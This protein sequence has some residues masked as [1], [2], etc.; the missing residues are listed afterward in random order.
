MIQRIQTVF[1]MI[2]AVALGTQVATPLVKSSVTDTAYYRDSLLYLK[3]YMPTLVLLIVT[4]ALV[5]ITIFLFKNR[6]LQKTLV[7]AGIV[8]ILAT[9]LVV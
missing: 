1:L 5:L 6:K 8:G 2:A 9:N 7:L 3:E 4:I